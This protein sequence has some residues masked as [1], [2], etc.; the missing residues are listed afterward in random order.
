MKNESIEYLADRILMGC[1][2]IAVAI[3]LSGLGG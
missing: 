2:A 1:A 3:V